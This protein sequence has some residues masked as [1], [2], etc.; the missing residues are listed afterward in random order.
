MAKALL[1]C[2]AAWSNTF[3]F[4]EDQVILS[5]IISGMRLMILGG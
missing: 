2:G 5:D 4:E 3:L 1:Y